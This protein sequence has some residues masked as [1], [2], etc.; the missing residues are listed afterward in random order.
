MRSITQRPQGSKLTHCKPGL[1]THDVAGPG[2]LCVSTALQLTRKLRGVRS[3]GVLEEEAKG[4]VVREEKKEEEENEEEEKWKMLGRLDS[5]PPRA[6]GAGC[7]RCD[8][9]VD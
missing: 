8:L 1:I 7:F 4:P 6:R 3:T 2:P 5:P 9:Q